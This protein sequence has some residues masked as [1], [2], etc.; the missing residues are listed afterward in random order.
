MKTPASAWPLAS[1]KFLSN[2]EMKSQ[3]SNV[4]L[5]FT[6]GTGIGPA[7]QINEKLINK[8]ARR[9]HIRAEPAVVIRTAYLTTA[10]TS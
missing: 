2:I 3:E 7:R 5:R 9:Q 4:V 10:L 6:A 1:C 8:L